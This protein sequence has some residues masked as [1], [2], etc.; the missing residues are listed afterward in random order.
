MKN[1]LP[2]FLLLVSLN[3]FAQ[4]IHLSADSLYRVSIDSRTLTDTEVGYNSKTPLTEVVFSTAEPNSPTM[5]VVDQLSHSQLWSIIV[6]EEGKFLFKNYKTKRVIFTDKILPPDGL[7]WKEAKE[8]EQWEHLPPG[9]KEGKLYMGPDPK[10]IG[11]TDEISY[12]ICDASDKVNDD[13]KGYLYPNKDD[14]PSLVFISYQEQ[15]LDKWTITPCYKI[16]DPNIPKDPSSSG[17]TEIDKVKPF[18]QTETGLDISEPCNIY[19]LGGIAWRDITGSVTLQAGV[20]IV[21]SSIT[22][23]S[24]KVVIL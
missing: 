23:T 13:D 5:V 2:L 9:V 18:R 22:R 12:F 15:I 16:G 6:G 4:T 24:W 17:I 19:T 10:D 8:T 7:S 20:Y 14:Q 1:I 21:Q 3:S 11:L